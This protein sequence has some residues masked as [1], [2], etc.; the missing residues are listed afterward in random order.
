V[1]RFD[2]GRDVL[3]QLLVDRNGCEFGRVDGILIHLREGKPPR[4]GEIE[5]G[6]FTAL[7]RVHQGLAGW[8]Q[9]LFARLSPVPLDSVRLPFDHIKR[10]GINIE[11]PV[12]SET[13][14]R[15]MRGEKWL[16]ARLIRKL[17]GAAK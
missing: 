6:M 13:D 1:A 17:P 5:T 14:D 3:D 12:D 15:L 11:M 10:I 7:R 8:L 16:R 2:V 9:R 4:L